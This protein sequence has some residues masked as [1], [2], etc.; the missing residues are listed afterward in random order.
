[1]CPI[2]SKLP[3]IE[4]HSL[5]CDVSYKTGKYEAV[6]FSNSFTAGFLLENTTRGLLPNPGLT[7]VLAPTLGQAAH[8]LVQPSLE[9][10]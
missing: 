4:S 2:S 1:M 10:P 3:I 5:H 9:H 6:N 7:A 8:C